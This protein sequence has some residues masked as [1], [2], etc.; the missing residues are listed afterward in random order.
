M[1]ARVENALSN[2]RMVV[3][4]VDSKLIE[5]QWRNEFYRCAT[6]L[7]PG[8]YSCTPDVGKIFGGCEGEID[9]Y[10]NG[11]LQWAIEVLR[12][13]DRIKTNLDRLINGGLYP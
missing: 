10:F 11:K 9:Y 4:G 12:E 5:R 6:S 8:Q 3:C 2:F 1:C 13:A 7:L